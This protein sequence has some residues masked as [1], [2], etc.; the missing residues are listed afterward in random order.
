MNK[1]I[2][3]LEKL[4]KRIDINLNLCKV[5][6]YGKESYNFELT[7]SDMSGSLIRFEGVITAKT[8]L[9]E[10]KQALQNSLALRQR[11]SKKL[12]NQIE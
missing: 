3:Y 12:Q 11:R 1:I 6:Q 9:R 7:K 2:E 10:F 5:N 8:D 4:S